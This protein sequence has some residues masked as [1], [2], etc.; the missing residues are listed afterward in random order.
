MVRH[1]DTASALTIAVTLL[2]FGIALFTK[3]LTHDLL[4]EAGV[5]LVSVK[6][7]LAGYK[8]AE[9]ADAL[10]AR[11]ARIEGALGRMEQVLLPSSR[12]PAA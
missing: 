3:G 6:L 4:L 5:F 1:L 11:L 2:L 7:I 12:P 8:S 9:T 10:Q